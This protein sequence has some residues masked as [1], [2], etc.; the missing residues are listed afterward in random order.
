MFCDSNI[1]LDTETIIGNF[2]TKTTVFM[3]KKIFIKSYN[4]V[5]LIFNCILYIYKCRVTMFVRDKLRNYKTDID[6]IVY[7]VCNLVQ[8]KYKIVFISIKNLNIFYCNNCEKES[9]RIL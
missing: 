1:Q 9:F 8:L 7:T 3:K 2:A 5:L 6:E 4:Y